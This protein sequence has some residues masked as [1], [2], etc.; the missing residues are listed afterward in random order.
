MSENFVDMEFGMNS[1][2]GTI[3]RN[4]KTKK[5]N[6]DENRHRKI[7]QAPIASHLDFDELEFMDTGSE[8][9]Y[10]ETYAA[11]NKAMLNNRGYVQFINTHSDSPNNVYSQKSAQNNKPMRLHS[12]ECSGLPRDLRDNYYIEQGALLNN[13]N[14]GDIKTP[15]NDCSVP[16][17]SN[18]QEIEEDS[19]I[20]IASQGGNTTT[21]ESDALTVGK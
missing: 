4:K 6:D 11:T 21:E 19:L 14:D 2:K 10:I 3:K 17:P 7:G 12:G 9:S 15:I 20:F 18:E 8:D 5:R 1:N 13:S 16:K